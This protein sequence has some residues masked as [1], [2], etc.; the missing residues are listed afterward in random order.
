MAPEEITSEW[1]SSVL[2]ADVTITGDQRIG[3]GLVGMNVRYSLAVPAGSDLPA[4]IIAKLPSPDPTS[5]ATGIA[6]RNYEREVKFYEQIAPTV[7]LVMVFVPTAIHRFTGYLAM[8][9]KSQLQPLNLLPEEAL[10]LEFS[11]GLYRPLQGWLTAPAGKS[12]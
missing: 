10:K 5:R 12:A 7:E 4:S 1:L 11:A 6:L 9:P 2:G 3:D 8:I